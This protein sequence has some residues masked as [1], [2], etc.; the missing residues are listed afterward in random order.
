MSVCV[1]DRTH[2]PHPRDPLTHSLTHSLLLD[3]PP[4]DTPLPAVLMRRPAA[5]IGHIIT[6]ARMTPC[7]FLLPSL[8]LIT[9]RLLIHIHAVVVVNTPLPPGPDVMV[10]VV[11]CMAVFL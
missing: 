3:V 10:I 1:K 6:G 9:P 8:L 7:P 4:P 11:G 5:A 2:A